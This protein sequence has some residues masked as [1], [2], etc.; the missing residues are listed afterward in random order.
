MQSFNTSYT[1]SMNRKY[2]KSGHL[3][4][5]RY[6]A[7]IVQ[8]ELYKNKLSRYIHLNPVKLESLKGNI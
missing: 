2:S 1:Q 8:T 5:G 6:K 7:Q 4:R 3:F